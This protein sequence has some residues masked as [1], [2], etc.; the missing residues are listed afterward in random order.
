M[1]V[2]PRIHTRVPTVS[3]SVRTVV[4]DR[5]TIA[6]TATVYAQIHDQPEIVYK[7]GDAS[8]RQSVERCLVA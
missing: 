8:G 1:G 7:K 6:W 3:D 5:P 4:G 2:L